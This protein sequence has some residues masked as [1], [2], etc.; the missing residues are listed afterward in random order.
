MVAQ[1]TQKWG[2]IWQM[3]QKREMRCGTKNK[4]IN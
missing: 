4:R 1:N 2:G 3:Q